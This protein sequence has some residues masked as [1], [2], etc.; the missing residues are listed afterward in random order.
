MNEEQ[1]DK[2]LKAAIEGNSN[3]LNELITDGIYLSN[4]KDL[5]EYALEMANYGG[6]MKFVEELKEYKSISERQQESSKRKR[7]GRSDSSNMPLLKRGRLGRPPRSSAQ[8]S[9]QSEGHALS[10]SKWI[11]REEKRDNKDIPERSMN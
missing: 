7:E 2:L 9:V 11:I 5:Y 3:S 10:P 6:H 4:K 1:E 8:R